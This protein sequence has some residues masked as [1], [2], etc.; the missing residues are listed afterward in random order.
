MAAHRYWRAT[1]FEAYAAGDLELSEFQLFSGATRVDAAATLTANIAPDISGALAD[2]QDGSVATAARWSARAVQGLTLQWDFGGSSQEVDKIRLAG[3][4]ESRF[5]LILRIDQSDNGTTWTTD[6]TYSG[7]PWPGQGTLTSLQD[8]VNGDLTF[9]NVS[10]LLSGNGGNGSTTILD[11]G[12]LGTA[13]SAVVGDV[14]IDTAQAKYGN[15]SILF[16]GAGDYLEYANISAYE[17][18]TGDFTIE[19]WVRFSA[20][21]ASYAGAYGAALVTQYKGDSGTPVGF[22]VRVNGSA[23]Q[24]DTINVY[25]GTSDLYFSGAAIP[26]NTWTHIAVSRRSGSIRAFVDGVQRGST[27]SNSDNFTA[28]QTVSRPL[29]IGQLND[30]T[31]KFSLNGRLADVRI[32]KGEGLYVSNFTPPAQALP[33]SVTPSRKLNT[34]RGRSAPSH[35]SGV[36][37]ST[38]PAEYGKG[39]DAGQPLYFSVE[40]GSVRDQITGVIGVGIGR[41]KGTVKVSGSP[42]VAVERKVRLIRDKDGLVL[43][44]MW[45]DKVSGEYDFRYIDEAQSFSVLSYDYQNNYRAVIADNLTLA[46]GGVELM[47]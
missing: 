16:D 22:Q 43:R 47:P 44:E 36:F 14:K 27:V 25:T 18:G 46:N 42:N 32:K 24:Y 33:V 7:I 37:G 45:S 10:L 35:P 40:S 38:P 30:E 21:S 8:R 31:F 17:F 23:S 12:P 4:S 5:A 9:S 39:N 34:V 26:L 41:V 15:A 19:C 11:S 3:D 28:S 6:E 29:R 2:L 20:Y 13:P 1:A